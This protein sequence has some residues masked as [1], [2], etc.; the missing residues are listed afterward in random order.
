MRITLFGATGLLGKP[1]VRQW[2]ADQVVALGSKDIDIRDAEKVLAIV[3]RTQPDC[4]VN[5]AAYTD[6]DGCETNRDLAFAVNSQ[7]AVNVATAA[8][9]VGATLIFLSTDYV[10]DGRTSKPYETAHPRAPRSVYGQSKA[11]AEE[12]IAEILPS[13]C[14]ARTSWLFGAGGKCFPDTI[15][16]LAEARHEIDVVDD[17]RGS[18]TYAPDLADAIIQLCRL[19]A[20]G[21]IHVTNAGECS[22]FEFAREIVS[23]AGLSTIVRPTTS[24]KFVRPAE[25]PKYSVLSPASLSRIGIFMPH[26][27]DA[28]RKYISERRETVLG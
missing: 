20:T 13:A 23:A 28:L 2:D 25:R 10:F 18:P 11:Q 16:K 3:R 7:G 9:D 15:I 19:R 22:W 1:L 5:A 27:K 26:W 24:D 17:Q 14:I 4:I 12:R 8:R 6:V 21:I